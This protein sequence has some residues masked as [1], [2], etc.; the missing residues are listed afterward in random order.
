[1]SSGADAIEELALDPNRK[2]PSAADD[3]VH[4]LV[5]VAS[6]GAAIRHLV[7]SSTLAA[8]NPAPSAPQRWLR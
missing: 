7:G 3:F 4:M 2:T 1:M 5:G 6:L 8:G